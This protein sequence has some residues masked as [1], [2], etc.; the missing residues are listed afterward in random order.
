MAI[1]INLFNLIIMQRTHFMLT[2]CSVFLRST[3][4]FS[5]YYSQLTIEPAWL[6]LLF[7]YCFQFLFGP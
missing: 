7:V 6:L 4:P 3:K 5:P 1:K 2:L